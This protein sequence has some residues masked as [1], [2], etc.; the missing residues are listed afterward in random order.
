MVSDNRPEWLTVQFFGEHVQ[1]TLAKMPNSAIASAIGVSRAYAGE[2]RKGYR[3]HPRHWETLAKL[4]A[5]S[6]STQS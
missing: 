6:A 2:I 5:V 1:P 3:P 4:V